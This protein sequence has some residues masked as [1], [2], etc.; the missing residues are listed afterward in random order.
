MSRLRLI[1]IAAALG[2]F[3]AG[4][5]AAP[6]VTEA[7]AVSTV[8]APK[9]T[10]TKPAEIAK[11]QKPKP[12]PVTMTPDIEIW[13]GEKVGRYGDME[14]EIQGGMPEFPT[15]TG[16]FQIEWKNRD[17]F[18]KQWQAP[19]PYAMFF[20]NGAAIHVGPLYGG[21]HGCVRVSE[22]TARYLFGQTK[23]Q[24]TRVFVYP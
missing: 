19:M 23:E 16:A 18:S 12:E 8:S 15:P 6:T 1:L 10:P 24:V 9:E 21:S 3:T 5:C 14:F 13:L 22:S 11:P 7:M 4:A 20:H 17:H 2:S